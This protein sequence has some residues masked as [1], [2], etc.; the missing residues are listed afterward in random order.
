M[1]H[2]VPGLRQQHNYC[3]CRDFNML[4][5]LF[6]DFFTNTSLFWEISTILKYI[7]I[8]NIVILTI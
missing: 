7:S 6:K 3:A 2:Y 4:K 5:M 1:T 8:L